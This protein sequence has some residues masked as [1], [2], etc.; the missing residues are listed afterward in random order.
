MATIKAYYRR[1]QQAFRLRALINAVSLLWQNN[2][3][4][5]T[6]RG[7][8]V[9]RISRDSRCCRSGDPTASVPRYEGL[10]TSLAVFYSARPRAIVTFR[11]R[12]EHPTAVR[13]VP[14][15]AI[16]VTHYILS[17]LGGVAILLVPLWL[18]NDVLSAIPDGAR[19][20][21]LA[22][23]GAALWLLVADAR[24]LGPMHKR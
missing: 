19:L 15:K 1:G 18:L 21:M 13:A 14:K 9:L 23:F 22:L 4:D 6:K 20:V 17:M 12:I 10:Q 7:W 16:N 11:F 24:F 8:D 2:Y 3:A 5:R